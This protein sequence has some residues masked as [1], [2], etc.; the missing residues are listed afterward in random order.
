M[1]YFV[2]LLKAQCIFVLTDHPSMLPKYCLINSVFV[3]AKRVFFVVPREPLMRTVSQNYSAKKTQRAGEEAAEGK[4]T[5]Y[6]FIRKFL[7]VRQ[8]ERWQKIVV[9]SLSDCCLCLHQTP[10]VPNFCGNIP[11]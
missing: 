3:W 11:M 4:I 6:T 5:G 8:R 9:V 2:A 7:V 1:V 10:C